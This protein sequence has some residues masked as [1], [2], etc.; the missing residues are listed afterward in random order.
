MI[1]T[2]TFWMDCP[3]HGTK[4]Y[5]NAGNF[6]GKKAFCFD[7][8]DFTGIAR[9]ITLSKGLEVN[10]EECDNRCLN[11]KKSCGCRCKGACHGMGTC[12]PDF[13]PKG[14]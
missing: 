11:G 5:A 1:A 14:E 10:R 13:H 6:D 9:I 2:K 8:K 4:E 7:C 3:T 12:N